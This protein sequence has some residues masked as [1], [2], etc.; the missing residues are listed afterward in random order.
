MRDHLAASGWQPEVVLCSPARRTVD[1]LAGIRTALRPDV[2]I[3]A[4]DAVYGADATR[5][6]RLVQALSDDLGDAMVVGHNP[7]LGE[8]ASLLAGSGEPDALDQ[9]RSKFPTGAIA[10][11]SFDG[12]WAELA[13]ASAQLEDLFM[14]RRPRS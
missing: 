11:V 2:R 4:V 1:T 12:P 14:P 9:L 8:L 5:L 10:T 3:E 13:P 7:G 6:L